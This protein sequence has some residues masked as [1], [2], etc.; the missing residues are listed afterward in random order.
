MVF[1]SFSAPHSSGSSP[2][3]AWSTILGSRWLLLARAGW[4]II[5]ALTVGLFAVSIPVEFAQLQLGCP[6]LSCA[7]SG[8]VAPVELL[9]LENFGLSSEFFASYGIALELVFTLVFVGVAALIFWRKSSDHQALFVSLAL[10]L[11]G[12]ATQPYA[13]HA[14]VAA[15]PFWGPLVD[16]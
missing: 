9:L 14:L 7:S 6:T 11:F 12:T 15:Y 10:L 16:C 3:S 2:G 4:L 5:A 8:G 1:S 13:L